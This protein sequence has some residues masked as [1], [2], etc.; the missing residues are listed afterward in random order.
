[1]I[2]R[3]R[4]LKISLAAGGIFASRWSGTV[5]PSFASTETPRRGKT[6]VV[7]FQRGGAD[8]LSMVVPHGDPAYAGL[9]PGIG[10]PPPGRPDGS[11]DLDGFFGLHPSLEP[12]H[13]YWK[14]KRLAAI[15]AVGSH[16]P[17]RSHFDAQDHMETGTPGN[18]QTSDGWLG[19]MLRAYDPQTPPGLRSLAIGSTMPRILRGDPSALALPSVTS[20]RAKALFGSALAFEPLY[21][22]APSSSGE[23]DYAFRLFDRLRRF[24]F[25]SLPLASNANYPRSPFGQAMREMAT[26]IKANL[27]LVAGFADSGGW[28]TH[29]NQ[30]GSIG[31][32]A[33]RLSDLAA[34][35]AAFS[36][37]LGRKLDDVVLLTMT[38]F[39]RTA[40]ENG[41][42]GTD[43]G[44]GSAF[45]VLGG[46]V[47]GGK[48]YGK[49]PGLRP[50]T[51]YEG[52]DL[53]VTSDFRDVV[54]RI[55]SGHLGLQR[56]DGV[57]PQ[58]P[59]AQEE[60]RH[61]LN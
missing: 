28:D 61:L 3:R 32:L 54:S 57:F 60:L 8:G 22:G 12:L 40:R 25:S 49:W 48:V 42:R 36:K 33:T 52:R 31:Q 39:G 51:L 45:F 9:R 2:S 44:H 24:D 46:S 26:V 20:P 16:D 21:A 41:N 11:V 53:A 59:P 37:D 55:L 29:V 38:E 50:E 19:R 14:E 27:G 43:H 23:G 13:L 47:R 5:P 15:H 56:L 4:L 1:M 35:I 58:H 30:G 18:K 6:L 34:G 7:V 10:I 17:T